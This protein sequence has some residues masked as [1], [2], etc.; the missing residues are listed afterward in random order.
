MRLRPL[1][2]A[3]A[4][5]DKALQIDKDCAAAHLG[6]AKAYRGK[7]VLDRALADFDEALKL[8]PKSA[9]THIDRGA[10]YQAEGDFDRAI[11][12]Y[13]EAIQFDP[14]DA[15]AFLGRANTY[16]GKHDLERTKQDLQAALR[17]DPRL[18]AAKGVLDEVNG[19][20]TRSAA[21]PTA[22]APTATSAPAP[23]VS[24]ALLVLL[25]LV[26]LIG[27]FAII[28]INFRSK[29]V[30]KSAPS[31]SAPANQT[32]DQYLVSLTPA[33]ERLAASTTPY[34]TTIV[35]ACAASSPCAGT[36]QNITVS[37]LVSTVSPQLTPLTNLLSF[38]TASTNAQTTTQSL[39]VENSGGGT[40]SFTSVTCG[41]SWCVPG[42]APASLGGGASENIS[43]QAN[44]AGL[45]AGFYFTELTIVSSAGTAEVPVNLLI[46]S[47][48]SLVLNPA[49]SQVALPAG[50]VAANP[51]TAFLVN[52]SG[53]ASSSAS[54]S[55]SA[56]VLPGATWLSV[57]TANG[58]STPSS[59]GSVSYSLSQSTIST[60]AA[61]VYYGTA[62][63]T[64]S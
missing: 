64:A 58:S 16:R 33:A 39:G 9:L 62:T 3:I 48:P 56:S 46:Q 42:P 13:D 10:I 37:L 4:D 36:S 18:A 26:A 6:R 29:P 22:A 38:N 61:G 34:S 17:R 63:R 44:P 20:L 21:S 5:Y 40:L 1:D 60:L 55:W 11:A 59:P 7:G 47:N 27:L 52:L 51:D 12:D 14:N 57:N 24:P 15:N 31:G 32:P 23:A 54:V 35:V 8:D 43:V 49:G 50:G 28:V 30:D 2:R 19:L 41:Q 53:A 45:S 25:A